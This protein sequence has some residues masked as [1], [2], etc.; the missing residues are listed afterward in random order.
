MKNLLVPAAIAIGGL[1]ITSQSLVTNC[2]NSVDTSNRKHDKAKNHRHFRNQEVTATEV[3]V[4]AVKVASFA[5][6][7]ETIMPSFFID[8]SDGQTAV[9]DIEINNQMEQNLLEISLPGTEA[10]D[11]EINSQMEESLIEISLQDTKLADLEIDSQMKESLVS[12]S[13]PD[14]SFSDAE[15]M[16]MFPA[17]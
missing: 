9:S 16:K 15:M 3:P 11:L 5:S 6:I 4:N 1:L 12:I 2:T 10:A 17:H 7:T 8:F 14:A 13:I